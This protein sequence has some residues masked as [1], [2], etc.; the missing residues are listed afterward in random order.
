MADPP[1][2][3]GASFSGDLAAALR[4]WRR[5]PLLPVLSVALPATTILPGDLALLGLPVLVFSAGW[6]GTERVWYLRAFREKPIR[7]PELWSLTRAFLGRYL[8]LGLL[9]GFV[10]ALSFLGLLHS[11]TL[12]LILAYALVTIEDVLLTFVTPALAF[13]TRRVPDALRIGFRMIRAEWPSCAWY[14]LVP[15]LAVVVVGRASYT[16]SDPGLLR[17][18]LV[19]GLSVLLNLWFKG[20]TAAFYLRRHEV[21]DDGAA[22]LPQRVE[23]PERTAGWP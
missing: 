2:S 6:V 20:A 14:V 4:V 18:H 11:K 22:F 13:S 19:S 12:W 3:S 16:Q 8:A 15:P 23:A 10:S 17:M 9:A 7:P 21:G 1:S 5:S